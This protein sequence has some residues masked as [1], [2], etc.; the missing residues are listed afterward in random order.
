MKISALPLLADPLGD[1]SVVVLSDG[2]AKRARIDEIATAAAAPA[3]AQ[4]QGYADSAQQSAAEFSIFTTPPEPNA[5]RTKLI[6]IEL[7]ASVGGVPIVLPPGT[8][9]REFTRDALGRA[10][11][12]VAVA[13]Q[14]GGSELYTPLFSFDY[15]G[16]NAVY[17][18]DW[19]HRVE[20]DVVA[21][22]TVLGVPV[23]TRLGS[24]TGDYLNGDAIGPYIGQELLTL[25]EGELDRTKLQPSRTAL[26]IVDEQIE[27]QLGSEARRGRGPWLA[28]V[29]DPYLRDLITRFV[30]EEGDADGRYGLSRLET[31]RYADFDRIEIMVRDFWLGIDVGQHRI[32]SPLGEQLDEGALPPRLIVSQ[33]TLPNW[34]GAQFY[35]EIDWSMIDW[36]YGSRTFTSWAQAGFDQAHTVTTE[37]IDSDFIFGGSRPARVITVDAA[38]A[39]F[40]TLRDAITSTHRSD[41]GVITGAAQPISFECCYSHQVKV[42]DR[43]EVATV[44]DLQGVFVPDY[45]TIEVM[46]APGLVE[47][48]A[49]TGGRIFELNGSYRLINPT[50]RQRFDEYAAHSDENN[51]RA[52]AATLGPAW[53]RWHPRQIEE[54]PHYILEPGQSEW[55]RGAGLSSGARVLILYPTLERRGGASNAF[56]GFHDLPNTVEGGWVKI[57]GLK[58]SANSGGGAEVALQTIFPSPYRHSV[59]IEDP[60]GVGVLIAAQVVAAD[61]HPDMQPRARDRI[62]WDIRVI[63]DAGAVTVDTTDPK[64][65]VASTTP[66]VA[67]GGAGAAL[68]GRYDQTLGR[69]DGLLLDGSIWSLANRFG[70]CR[71]SP[72]PISIGAQVWPGNGD[73]RGL[74]EAAIL[75]QINAALTA[76]PI[77]PIRIDG[78]IPS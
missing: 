25:A 17:A 2:S 22:S 37:M 32:Q 68:L 62:G 29:R 45:M 31:K 26:A 48:V 59:V 56:F 71:A 38:G 76:N 27:Q 52:R 49:A 41:I 72:K 40:T 54:R 53:Q 77:V 12:D 73:Y 15:A 24:A 65:R 14:V 39:D 36:N 69:W 1:E 19:R 16:G 28:S 7:L 30:A 75:A 55:G 43:R 13:L 51:Q 67:I 57:V 74:T 18:P 44:E 5:T 23:G 46:A 8:M 35:F 70:D 58:A 4:A 6:K 78:E 66:G 42:V 34:H 11:L 50:L 60:D 9:V 21:T 64:M 20:T 10:R 63:G 47:Y 33:G 61:N 3:V